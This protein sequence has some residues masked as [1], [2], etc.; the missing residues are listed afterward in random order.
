[1]KVEQT[2]EREEIVLPYRK[3]IIINVEG[4]K[5]IEISPLEHKTI[6]ASKI[7]QWMLKLLDKILGRNRVFAHSLKVWSL[8][9]LLITKIKP[10]RNHRNQ[11]TKV[12]ITSSKT[13]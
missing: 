13:S 8:R 1:M 2:N 5:Q 12:N 6:I 11:V 10:S 3:I 7:Y 9:Y 4:M